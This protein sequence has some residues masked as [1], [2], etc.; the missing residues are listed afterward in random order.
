MDSV[1]NRNMVE[2]FSNGVTTC[3]APQDIADRFYNELTDA[4][5]TRVTDWL[6][7]ITDDVAEQQDFSDSDEFCMGLEV[8]PKKSIG[9]DYCCEVENK[10]E[11]KS[12]L[13]RILTLEVHG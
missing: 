5:R 7:E 2:I 1:N 6:G 12:I 13:C 10:T 3:I 8:G 9:M 11:G 4:E